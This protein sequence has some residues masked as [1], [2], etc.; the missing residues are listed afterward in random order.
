MTLCHIVSE[1]TVIQ[2]NVGCFAAGGSS[3]PETSLQCS[4]VPA[5]NAMS[6]D[7]KGTGN[8][9]MC[10]GGFAVEKPRKLPKALFHI[11][12]ILPNM[13]QVLPRVV[14]FRSV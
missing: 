10:V 3:V 14:T 8:L 13:K 5:D 12:C 9:P 2:R 6:R 11:I 7:G 4:S 1:I